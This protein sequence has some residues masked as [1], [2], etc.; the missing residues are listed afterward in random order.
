[1]R[2]RKHDKG[3]FSTIDIP[4]GEHG[5]FREPWIRMILTILPAIAP[6]YVI[7]GRRGNEAVVGSR[8]K[9]LAERLARKVRIQDGQRLTPCVLTL[10]NHNVKIPVRNLSGQILSGAV[11]A[12]TR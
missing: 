5:V 7:K 9:G 10:A 12:R 4:Y 6:I 8:K 2:L 1:M 3:K 11:D